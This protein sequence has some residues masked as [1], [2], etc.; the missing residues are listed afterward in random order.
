MASRHAAKQNLQE[1][2]LPSQEKIL[3]RLLALQMQVSLPLGIILLP[4]NHPFAL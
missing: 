2:K 3:P 4:Q 1:Q